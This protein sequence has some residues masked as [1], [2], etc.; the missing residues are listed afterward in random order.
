MSIRGPCTRCWPSMS[1][2]PTQRGR[3]ARPGVDRRRAGAEVEIAPDGVLA[4]WG[5]RT[6]CGHPGRWRS[7]RLCHPVYVT[8]RTPNDASGRATAREVEVA[9]EVGRSAR[10]V[11]LRPRD[12]PDQWLSR[13]RGADDVPLD[14]CAGRVVLHQDLRGPV[15]ELV[16][17]VEGVVQEPVVERTPRVDASAVVGTVAVPAGGDPDIAAPGDEVVRH[18][19]VVG[20]ACGRSRRPP[21]SRCRCRRP[22]FARR[23]CRSRRRCRCRRRS[24]T[25][26]R[27]RSRRGCHGR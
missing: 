21:R 13:T 9:V 12:G 18:H 3:T 5:R 26:R 23:G 1:R 4:A 16:V 10:R 8:P 11:V 22:G 19:D 17:R 14:Q 27:P 24:C 2:R 20:S 15:D 6:G 7:G 25:S